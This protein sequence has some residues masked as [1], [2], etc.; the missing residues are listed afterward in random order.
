M[1]IDECISSHMYN[2]YQLPHRVVN[3]LDIGAA[4]I[5]M[6]KACIISK[7]IWLALSMV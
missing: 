7:T 1:V 2:T 3:P 5:N 4:K 6:I